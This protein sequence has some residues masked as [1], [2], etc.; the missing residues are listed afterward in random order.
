MKK[1]SLAIGILTLMITCFFLSSCGALI[2]NDNDSIAIN[3]LKFL[4]KN[5]EKG[6]KE[7]IKK[8]FAPN[9]IEQLEDIDNSIDRLC[10]YYSGDYKSFSFVGLSSGGPIEHGKV[11]K[12]IDSCYD[13]YTTTQGFHIGM[14]WYIRDDNDEKN[15]G[16]WSLYIES[17]FNDSQWTTIEEWEI[18]IHLR[19]S[20]A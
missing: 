3:N 13:V 18:G 2:Y 5:L 4:V 1:I 8:L 20:R 11:I 16:L 10:S 15:V 17:F 12:Y 9:I 19:P 7:E 14:E 6:N